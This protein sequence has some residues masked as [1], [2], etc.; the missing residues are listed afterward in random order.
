MLGCLILLSF[1]F[2]GAFTGISR[3]RWRPRLLHITKIYE[4]PPI[5]AS[6][7]LSARRYLL[8][9]FISCRSSGTFASA[10]LADSDDSVAPDGASV[11]SALAA[12]AAPFSCAAGVADSH[13]AGFPAQI[14]FALRCC[15]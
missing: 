8:P 7:E 4:R 11:A 12:R 5:S 15:R 2:V 6:R 14:F 1:C 3:R 13:R 10:S 9:A